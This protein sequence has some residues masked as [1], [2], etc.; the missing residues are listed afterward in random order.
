MA[1]SQS[2]VNLGWGWSGGKDGFSKDTELSVDGN[3][4]Y[5]DC[6]GGYGCVIDPFH[7]SKCILYFNK[8]D[9]K[10]AKQSKTKQNKTKQNKTKKQ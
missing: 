5:L 7:L 2:E 3:V 8:V 6:G 9:L 1:K 10:K 4:L